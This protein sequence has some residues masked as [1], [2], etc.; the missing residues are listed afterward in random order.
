M[1]NESSSNG[2]G[3]DFDRC[4]QTNTLNGKGFMGSSG[5][6]DTIKCI[7][8]RKVERA[9]NNINGISS[10]DGYDSSSYPQGSDNS[11]DCKFNYN[12]NSVYINPSICLP[13][14][15]YHGEFVKLNYYSSVD[16]Y[17]IFGFRFTIE[18]Y[19]PNAN[20]GTLRVFVARKFGEITGIDNQ[21]NFK[22]QNLGHSGKRS[23][24]SVNLNY[25]QD[26]EPLV[27]FDVQKGDVIA[28]VYA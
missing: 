25:V 12:Q 11:S 5:D 28:V 2:S 6:I 15:L 16:N 9:V 18:G 24:C 1:G 22:V 17:N 8:D 4:V 19:S 10:G 26:D 13:Q 14:D 27:K 23:V 20:V 3:S 21:E 7:I